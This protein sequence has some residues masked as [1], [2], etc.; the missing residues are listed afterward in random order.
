MT[1]NDLERRLSKLEQAVEQLQA[2][3]HPSPAQ[4][5]HWWRNEAG[6]FADDPLFNEMVRLVQAHRRSLRAKGSKKPA[7]KKHAHT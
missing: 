2:Q 4:Q 3:A 7:K 1:L 5:H 6:R